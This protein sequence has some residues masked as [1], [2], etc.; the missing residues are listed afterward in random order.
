VF[1]AAEFIRTFRKAIS[2]AMDSGQDV[3]Q[4]L[5]DMEESAARSERFQAGQ[6]S[7]TRS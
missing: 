5:D 2:M 3:W 7:E 4:V 6:D 1:T